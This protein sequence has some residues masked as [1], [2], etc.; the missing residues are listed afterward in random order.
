MQWME[1]RCPWHM[2]DLPR[3]WVRERSNGTEQRDAALEHFE[4]LLPREPGESPGGK[5]RRRRDGS[6][7]RFGTDVLACE[8]RPVEIEDPPEVLR[9]RGILEEQTRIPVHRYA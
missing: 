7:R 8:V 2:V 3:R 5:Y 1:L 4:V 9:E 6:D